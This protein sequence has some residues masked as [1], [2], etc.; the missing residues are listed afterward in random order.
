[1]AKLLHREPAQQTQDDLRR[2]KQLLETGELATVEG[3]P[4]AREEDG[5]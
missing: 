2:L 1:V 4:S 5:R 3:Q